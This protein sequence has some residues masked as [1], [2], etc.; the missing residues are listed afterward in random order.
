VAIAAVMFYGSMAVTTAPGV[1]IAAAVIVEMVVV[2][3]AMRVRRGGKNSG[4]RCRT[5]LIK[6]RLTKRDTCA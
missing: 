5:R 6:R 2:L 1:A 3:T 4:T